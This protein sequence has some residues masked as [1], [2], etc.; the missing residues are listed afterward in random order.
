ME[1]KNFKYKDKLLSEF[2]LIMCD[3]NNNSGKN[4]I[5]GAKL[6]FETV[7]PPVGEKYN[8]TSAS[9]ES[10][11][12]AP[13]GICKMPCNNTEDYFNQYELNDIISWLTGNEYEE[14][15]PCDEEFDDIIFYGLFTKIDYVR[16]G[17]HIYKL[18]VTFETNSSFACGVERDIN[19]E[20]LSTNDTYNIINDS[21]EIG[22]LSPAFVEIKLKEKGDLLIRNQ[23]NDELDLCIKNCENNEIITIDNEHKILLSTE[24]KHNLY[25]DFNYHFLKLYK[26]KTEFVNTLTFS[27]PCTVRIK[28][29]PLRKVPI[30][31]Q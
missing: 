3:P 28:Y 16:H 13:F 18:I 20:I 11:L 19:F 7:K 30:L 21:D 14:F 6:V 17:E 5:E 4:T 10:P 22:Y 31:C 1:I 27:L 23:L 8:K 25:D 12:S 29:R 9:Y 24:N 26:T 2:G 15:Q